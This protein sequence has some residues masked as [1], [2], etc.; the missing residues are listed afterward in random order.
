MVI[1]QD[2]DFVLACV[3][4]IA[5]SMVFIIFSSFIVVVSSWVLYKKHA[6]IL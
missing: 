6:K 3:V 4:A 5:Y 2:N 1:F